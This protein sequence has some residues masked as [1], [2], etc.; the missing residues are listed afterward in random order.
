MDR[1]ALVL[2]LL[3]AALPA[4]LAA[5]EAVRLPVEN[6]R[7]PQFA[8]E[9]DR[10]YV[11]FGAGE[12]VYCARSDDGPAFAAP[13]K[14][15]TLPGL[16]LGKRRGPR[17]AAT[18]EAVVVTAIESKT[19]NLVAW[20]SGDRGATWSPATR[21]NDVDRSGREGLHDTTAGPGDGEVTA[22]WLDLRNDR[23]EL[24]ADVSADGGATWRGN[25]LV[26]RSPEKS[27]CECCHPTLAA[28]DGRLIALWRNHLSGERD[29]YVSRSEDGGRSFGEAA[30]L[31]RQRWRLPACPMDGGDLAA[32]PAG[33]WAVWRRDRICYAT[34][35]ADAKAERRL[36]PGEQPAVAVTPAGPAFAWLDR[37]PGDLLALLPGESEPRKI[38]DKAADP[39]LVVT[40]SGRVLA[41]WERQDAGGTSVY[42]KPLMS[43][44][45]GDRR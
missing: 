45:P 41:A 9:G 36:G 10:L 37:R 3:F 32:G 33:A 38:A 18:K 27:V 39:M 31:G 15:A 14:V 8:A 12:D 21:V 6:A 24:W 2:R 11:A 5:A 29:M 25:R 1:L 19:G 17:V 13:I 28:A 44:R 4:P 30:M 7:Q 35:L 34:D 20:R 23:T 16:M 40:G 26:Y 22:A 42:V 43:A